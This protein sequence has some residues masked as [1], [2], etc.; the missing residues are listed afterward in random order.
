MKE[1]GEKVEKYIIIGIVAVIVVYIIVTFNKLVSL[2][3]RVRNQ[4]S[5]V[6]VQLKKRYNLVPNLVETVKGYA[7]H[8]KNTLEAVMR[9]RSA[10]VD[11]NRVDDRM[12]AENELANTLSR[13][14]AVSESYPELKANTNFLSLQK[15]LADIEA[16]IAY[17]RQFYNDT[18]MKYQDKRQMFPTNIV[19]AIFGFKEERYFEA[20]QAERENVNVQF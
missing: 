16:S 4:W 8:E 10:T 13:L 14:I 5:Q 20:G 19:A 9:A 18:V 17:A 6:D 15:S 12:R 7:A 11:T 3:N 2:R 1:R